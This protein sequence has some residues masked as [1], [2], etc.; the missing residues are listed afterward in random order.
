MS[1]EV[2]IPPRHEPPERV[3]G[4]L[5]GIVSL[6]GDVLRALPR[7]AFRREV[8]AVRVLRRQVV[9]VNHPEVVR[10]VFV[11]RGAIYGRKSHFKEQALSPVIGESLFA[12]H[13]PLWAARR[14]AV[15]RLLHPSGVDRF[16]PAFQ[17]TGR[18]LL[19]DWR[20]G[21]AAGAVDVAPALAAATLRIMLH[22]VFGPQVPEDESTAI[23][24]AFS[25][26]QS[27]VQ[28]IDLPHLVGLPSWTMGLQGVRARRAANEI[29]RRVGRLIASGLGEGGLLPGM[30]AARDEAGNPLLDEAGLLDEVAMMLLAGSETAANA[31]AWTL[32][33]LASDP[34]WQERV[35]AEA[36][37]V[38]GDREP[39]AAELSRLSVNKA[40]L[41]EAM[42]LYPPVAILARQA[43]APDR[44]RH[45][46]LRPGDTLL[47][48][49]WLLHRQEAIWDAPHAFK[50]ER[51]LP[52][53]ARSIPRFAYL[54]F[55]V[56]ARVCA[57]AAFGMAEMQTL[58]AMLV[59]GFHFDP[60]EGPAPLPRFRLTLR[61]EGGMK[62]RLRPL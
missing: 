22:A 61:P 58:L 4:L 32:F 44:I 23:A 55:G 40:V 9:V 36:V 20:A 53:N 38:L 25:D 18:V 19:R 57:G 47:C 39:E 41:Q 37:A 2:F 33:L 50:P 48:I 43:T 10:D 15:A 27:R 56:G 26:Y 7:I 1:T 11:T 45:W 13:G 42:R 62:L 21:S 30:R 49:P 16:Q 60:P 12:N 3:P 6:R 31:L 17:D 8:M 51:F 54:P 24:E 46:Q 34:R 35:R 59:R 29:R 5:R 14:P 28:V 52:E